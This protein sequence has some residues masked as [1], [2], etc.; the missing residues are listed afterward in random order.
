MT[1]AIYREISVCYCTHNHSLFCIPLHH[2]R[3]VSFMDGRLGS[4]SL[5]FV[6]LVF[7]VAF[8]HQRSYR[9]GA[10]FLVLFSRK[11]GIKYHIHWVLNPGPVVCKSIMLSARP[12]LLLAP[13]KNLMTKCTCQCSV[14]GM[15]LPGV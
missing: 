10:C 14:N 12:Q 4:G 6:C 13:Y 3:R 11:L 5:R 7:N 2:D 9:F 15:T 1:I 8:K